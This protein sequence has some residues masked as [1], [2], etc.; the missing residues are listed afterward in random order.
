LT[1]ESSR[2][3]LQWGKKKKKVVEELHLT[4]M[5]CVTVLRAS[6]VYMLIVFEVFGNKEFRERYDR[7]LDTNSSNPY[8]VAVVELSP[9]CKLETKLW[10]L[11]HSLRDESVEVVVTASVH[12][13]DAVS[14]S[15]KTPAGKNPLKT[16][17]QPGAESKSKRARKGVGGLSPGE[18]ERLC[19]RRR[20][21]MPNETQL[22]DLTSGEYG[23][24]I[25]ALGSVAGDLGVEVCELLLVHNYFVETTRDNATEP[26]TGYDPMRG[27]HLDRADLLSLDG[28][29]WLTDGAMEEVGRR[30]CSMVPDSIFFGPFVA[31]LMYPLDNTFGP[32]VGRL[33]SASFWEKCSGGRLLG[34]D[35]KL[36]AGIHWAIDHWCFYL[37]DFVRGCIVY[38]DSLLKALHAN[39]FTEQLKRALQQRCEAQGGAGSWRPIDFTVEMWVHGPLQPL[40]DGNNCGVCGILVMEWLPRGLGTF[41]AEAKARAV[42]HWTEREIRQ[43]RA[44]WACE[45]L[46]RPHGTTTSQTEALAHSRIASDMATLGEIEDDGDAA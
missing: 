33:P 41:Y 31:E 25:D 39:G 43:A 46:L 6:P 27:G 2:I 19:R 26:V 29:R 12:T 30:V 9:G 37:V 22:V 24:S 1:W 8:V 21:Y 15:V 36:I 5:D 28:D 17:L 40:G 16:L 32:S 3:T 23:N 18:H 44:R 10:G 13:K 35:I 14:N 42:S 45:L 7:V 11:V 38:Y 4:K 34:D 20:M